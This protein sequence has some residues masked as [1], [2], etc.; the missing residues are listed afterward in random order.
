MEKRINK[1]IETYIVEFKDTIRKKIDELG[2]DEKSKVND[3]LE[4]VY[5][6][7]RLS[8]TKDD[9][10]KRKRIQNSIP[11]SNRCN[12]R[13]A[14]N[15][16]CTRRRKTDS[17]YCG[18]HTKGTPNGCLNANTCNNSNEQ[19]L[20]VVAKEIDGIVYYI[21]EHMNVYRTEDILNS[22]ENP[23]II[24]KYHIENGKTILGKFL[25]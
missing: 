17:E 6:Y 21:D 23:E 9:F 4:H 14:N 20:D 12:A 8:L 7:Q 1:V 11:V 25:V 2:F 13:R 15:E 18:T 3:L 16:Q 22:K 24:A 19:K 10:I 5:D